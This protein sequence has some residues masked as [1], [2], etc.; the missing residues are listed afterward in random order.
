MGVGGMDKVGVGG[1]LDS[2]LIPT[3]MRYSEESRMK[4]KNNE[5]H[6]RPYGHSIGDTSLQFEYLNDGDSTH[7]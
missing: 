1:N 3:I 7:P 2:H 4:Q 5:H 6:L